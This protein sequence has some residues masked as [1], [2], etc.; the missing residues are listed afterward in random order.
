VPFDFLKPK[1]KQSSN[2]QAQVKTNTTTTGRYPNDILLGDLMVKSGVIS[3]AQLDDAIKLAGNKHL[4]LGQMLIMAGNISPRDLQA[5]VD[6]QSMLRDKAVDQNLASRCLKIACKTGMSFIDVVRDQE[7]GSKNESLSNKLGELLLSAHLIDREQFGKSMQ[8]SLATGLPLGRILVLNGALSETLLNTALEIQ[9][10]IR[11]GMLT[12]EEAIEA[13][14]GQAGEVDSEEAQRQTVKLQTVMAAAPRKK[15]IRLG[16][17]MVLAGLLNETDVMS[18]L[19]LGLVNEQ[20]IGQ[21]LV[22]QGFLTEEL[23]NIALELQRKVDMDELQPVEAGQALAKISATGIDISEAVEEFIQPGEEV[24]EQMTFDKMITLARVVTLEDIEAALEQCTQSA[25]ILAKVLVMTNFITDATMH[26]ILQCYSMM[27]NN[28]L[29]QDDAIIALDYCLHKSADRNITFGEALQELGW[30]ATQSLQMQAKNSVDI[31]HIRLQAMLGPDSMQPS[32]PNAT[33][34]LPAYQSPEL[35]TPEPWLPSEDGEQPPDEAYGQQG[36][37]FGE[38]AQ[39]EAQLDESVAPEEV[40]PEEVFTPEVAL[41]YEDEESVPTEM[42]QE[43]VLPEPQVFEEAA[44]QELEAIVEPAM[45]EAAEAEVQSEPEAEYPTTELES[46]GDGA[47]PPVQTAVGTGDDEFGQP[48]LP[49]AASLS[50]LLGQAKVQEDAIAADAEQKAEAAAAGIESGHI[51]AETP[52]PAKSYDPLRDLFKPEAMAALDAT[53]RSGTPPAQAMPS[54]ASTPPGNGK[55]VHEPLPVAASAEPQPEASNGTGLSDHLQETSKPEAELV[56]AGRAAEEI[57][58]A[59]ELNQL[60]EV[61]AETAVQPPRGLGDLIKATAAPTA[62]ADSAVPAVLAQALSDARTAGMTNNAASPAATGGVSSLQSILAQATLAAPQAPAPPVMPTQSA[63]SLSSLV[64]AGGVPPSMVPSAPLPLSSN[65]PE[66]TPEPLPV[67]SALLNDLAPPAPPPV[68]VQAVEAPA[69]PPVVQPA[70]AMSEPVVHMSVVPEPVVPMSVVPEPVMPMPVV[71]EPAAAVAQA[72]QIPA[73]GVQAAPVVQEAYAP[74]PVPAEPVIAAAPTPTMNVG[75]STTDVMPIRP[76]MELRPGGP[77]L[78]TPPPLPQAPV[79]EVVPPPPPPAPVPEVVPPAPAPL[80]ATPAPAASLAPP[81]APVAAAQPALDTVQDQSRTLP[82][83][84]GNAMQTMQT[85]QP[86]VTSGQPG[87]TPPVD[88]EAQ[89]EL[90][91]ALGSAL[92]RLAESYYE[93]G[94]FAEA[95]SLYERILAIKQQQL[96]PKHASIG[97]DLTNLAGVLCVQGKFDQAEPFVKRVVG[98]IESAVPLDVLKL[99]DSLN[100]LAG[101]LFQQGKYEEC[102]PLLG[103]ALQHRQEALGL[104]HPEIAD[105]LRDY[106]KLLRKLKREEEAERMY[107]Q[108][109]AILARRPKD[110]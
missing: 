20:P 58:A 101:I 31:T 30:S 8:R 74:P 99:A 1:Q 90:K 64:E 87:E 104:D 7:G 33:Q 88:T 84:V 34:D 41:E 42:A 72:P 53:E 69:P 70:P 2:S 94:D 89:S 59:A 51:A 5:A 25:Q 108:A 12:R 75:A 106:A 110:A 102:E 98:I 107:A 61:P 65:L 18:A 50:E 60:V 9:V 19:E 66:P 62:A 39:A 49:E 63:P 97:A 16:E 43:E 83:G 67:S 96:G 38:A 26:A 76:P 54:V 68:A 4:Q 11:D 3:Q 36:Q 105:N 103:R 44:Q 14:R 10:R 57:A 27:S 45:A 29:S 56:P 109:K 78:L 81:P 71:P 48:R 17:L 13:L 77:E 24:Y 86:Y 23:L 46:S 82:P 28:F 37:E 21:V 100:T 6:A 35:L 22:F 95:Q 91:E 40:L 79:S 80:P 52:A 93:Q 15:G 32:N 85:L 73:P 55:V 47:E 92:N